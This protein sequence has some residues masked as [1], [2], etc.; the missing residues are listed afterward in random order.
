MTDTQRWQLAILTIALAALTYWLKPVLTPFAAAALIAYLGDPVVARLARWKLSRT[1]AVTLVFAVMVLALLVLLLVLVPLIEAQITR[2]IARLPVYLDWIRGNAAPWL[3]A[4]F[5]VDP[6]LFDTAQI[7]ALLQEHWKEAGGFAA[8][9]LS[10]VSHSGWALLHG[11]LG[12]LV[13]PVVAFYLMRDWP[14]FVARVHELIPRPIEPTV[15]R[16]ARESDEVLGA[17][18]RGQL[19]VMLVLGI[20]YSAALAIMGLDLALLIGMGAGAISFVPYLGGIVGI[21][22]GLIAAAVQFHDV[23]HVVIVLGIFWVGHMLEGWVLAPWLVGDKI[24]LHPVAVIFAI[25]C[26]AELGG[27]L[28]VLLALPVAAVIAVL[29]R[30]AHERY[31]D[32]DLYGAEDVPAV[33]VASDAAAVPKEPAAAE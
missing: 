32:S 12:A 13:V 31:R 5:G 22:A 26:G 28:G 7:V 16:L 33:P 3:A 10:T 9:V 23:T 4:N 15:T 8:T 2:L 17:F 18:V 20:F 11:V 30:H 25:F 24:G 1:V 6:A 14:E 29:L 27:F 19:L 21:G